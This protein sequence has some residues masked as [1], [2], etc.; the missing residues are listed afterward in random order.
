MKFTGNSSG[1]RKV[2]AALLV[3]FGAGALGFCA[4]SDAAEPTGL[5]I[6]FGKALGGSDI[7]ADSMMIAQ[8]LAEQRWTAFLVTHGDGAV[9]RG[10]RVDANVGAGIVRSTRLGHWSVGFGAALFEHGNAIVGPRGIDT[11]EPPRNSE[12]VQFGA[13]ISVRRY[14]SKRLV[15]DI[16]HFSTG[17]AAAHNSGLNAITLG[18]RL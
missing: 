4:K 6:G 18:V 5:S 10:E 11:M 12:R 17:G 1:V 15:V 9:C 14:V 16:L 7:C 2:L 8:E 3:A 13:A